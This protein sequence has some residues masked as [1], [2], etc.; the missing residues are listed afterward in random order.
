MTHPATSDR[1]YA[2][3]QRV[4]HNLCNEFPDLFKNELECLKDF[5]L[6]VKFKSDAKPVFHKA[7]PV[8][9]ALRD[10]LEKGYG[11]GITKGVCMVASPI[12]RIR[13]TTGTDSQSA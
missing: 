12:Q 7:R 13:N 5:E 2:A 3:L 6:E 11:D 9:F 8:L 1:T 10:D 4:C